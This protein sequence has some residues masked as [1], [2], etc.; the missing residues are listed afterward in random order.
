MLAKAASP[1]SKLTP[2]AV[3][4]SMASSG[5]LGLDQCSLHSAAAPAVGWQ[6]CISM[7]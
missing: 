2:T 4:G 7:S 6:Y 3:A 5:V 1:F